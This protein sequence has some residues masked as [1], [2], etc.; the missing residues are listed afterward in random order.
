[1]ARPVVLHFRVTRFTRVTCVTRV[2]SVTSG[3]VIDSATI[4]RETICESGVIGNQR[5]GRYV[6]QWGS[7]RQLAVHS[8]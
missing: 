8:H 4:A 6:A 2:T 1:M 7:G 3:C 5:A